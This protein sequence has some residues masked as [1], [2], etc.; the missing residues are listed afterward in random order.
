ML[1]SLY[2]ISAFSYFAMHVVMLD[3]FKLWRIRLFFLFVMKFCNLVIHFSKNEKDF[4]WKIYWICFFFTFLFV[5]TSL[6]NLENF[7]HLFWNPFGFYE[8]VA[9]KNCFE[10]TFNAVNWFD[11]TSSKNLGCLKFQ[12]FVFAMSIAQVIVFLHLKC[13]TCKFVVTQIW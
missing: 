1:K 3:L 6:I 9:F 12:V 13:H 4:G 5:C 11:Y 8:Q 2:R 10:Y 7:Y